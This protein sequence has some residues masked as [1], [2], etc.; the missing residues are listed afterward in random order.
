MEPAE[1][2]ADWLRLTL[3]PGVGGSTQRKLLTA[4]GLPSAI[5]SADRNALGSV[6]G[7]QTADRLLDTDNRNA[8][9]N[10]LAWSEMPHHWLLCLA[11]AEYPQDLLQTPDPPLLIYVRG[12]LAALN[13]K[14]LAI[15][16]S[17]NPTPQGVHNSEQFAA[18][19][20]KAGM[21]IASGLALGIDAAAHRGALVSE[22][23]TV[24]FVGTG[25][26][27]IYPAAN[28]QLAFEIA[29]KGAI[30]SEFPLGTPPAAANFPRRN[31]L[32]AGFSR[33]TLV[34]EATIE[35]GS[36]ITARFSA[37]QGREVFAI[38][39]SIHSPQSRGCHRLIK[40]GAKLVETVEDVLEELSW[41]TRP[42]APAADANGTPESHA[43]LPSIGYDP[44][45]IDEIASRSGLTADVV[46]A[47]LLQLELA[48][49]VASLPGGR[50]QRIPPI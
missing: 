27:R 42:S 43:L 48:G 8:V 28:R 37:E 31:R 9:K 18:A 4:F 35:S 34:V 45:A 29:D 2:L 44:C 15:V 50:Y 20:S 39:G 49:L 30:V 33:G 5:F 10:A 23:S 14:A 41:A 3:I 19:L 24:A 12:H 46:S 40:Q 22:G 32:I 1:S 6:V 36:L 16:G 17:R 21:T 26:D 38:P 11:D 13:G 47:T 7:D 25:I